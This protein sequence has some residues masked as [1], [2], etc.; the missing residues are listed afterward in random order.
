MKYTVAID[1]TGEKNQN[2][3]RGSLSKRI[4]ELKKRRIEHVDIPLKT[5]QKTVFRKHEFIH[6]ILGLVS[7]L[8]QIQ[9]T[10]TIARFLIRMREICQSLTPSRGIAFINSLIDGT[11]IQKELEIWKTNYSNN[12][13]GSMGQSY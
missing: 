9:D 12:T 10:G 5:I 7:P 1:P 11:P 2:A 13:S 8:L 3:K 6:H 4:H